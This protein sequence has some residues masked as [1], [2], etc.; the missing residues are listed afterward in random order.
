M[1]ERS[2]T[3]CPFAL[4]R[5]LY[6]CAGNEAPW[7]ADYILTLRH[8]LNAAGLEDVQ[9]TAA[10]GGTD[11]IKAAAS[12][13][14]LANAIGSFGIHTHVLAPDTSI[15]EWNGAKGCLIHSTLSTGGFGVQWLEFK[16]IRLSL[17]QVFQHRK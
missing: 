7:S 1:N 4:I 12:N 8:S 5:T 6:Y 16:R 17:G 14:T 15:N 13:K 9:I 3:A 11:V 2:Q 10:D